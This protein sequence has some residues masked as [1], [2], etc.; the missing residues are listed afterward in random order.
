MLARKSQSAMEYLMTYGW[1]ILIIAVV[2]GAIYSLGLFNGATLAPRS[3]PGSCQVFRP[4]GPGTTQYISLAGTCTNE[5]PQYAAKFIGT[6]SYVTM[7]PSMLNSACFGTVSL[8]FNRN[9]WPNSGG[10]YTTLLTKSDGVAWNNDHIQISQDSGGNV[11]DLEI[12][13]DVAST[14]GAIQTPTVSTG[15]WYQI[16]MTWNGVALVGYLNGASIGSVSTTICEPSDSNLFAIGEGAGGGARYFN[17]SIANVQ[18]YNA[19]LDSNSIQALYVSGVGGSPIN[20]QSLVAWYPLNGNANDYSGNLNNG[21][22]TAVTYTNQWLGG[23][24]IP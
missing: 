3:S 6:G 17:G 7:N 4:N 9:S 5:I 24:T 19:S 23:Y 15:R 22:S 1:A 12:A 16:A 13:N 2:L 11:I 20:L 10:T 8:W 14:T 21:A 18:I